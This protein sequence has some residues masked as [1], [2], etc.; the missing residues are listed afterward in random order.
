VVAETAEKLG[1]EKGQAIIIDP[2][3]IDEG[4]INL[5]EESNYDLKGVLL[6]HK[7][8]NHCYGLHCLKRIYDFE[9]Y[10]ASPL[11]QGHKSNLIKDGDVFTVGPFKIKAVSVPGHSADSMVYQINH[12]LFTGDALSAG[13]IG[14]TT[15]SFGAVQQVAALENKVFTMQGSYIVLPGHGPPSTLDA[16]RRFNAGIKRYH[17][18][19]LRRSHKYSLIMDM[20]E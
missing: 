4:I 6:T 13:M 15:N 7:H 11:V 1:T 9:L 10:A 14:R 5:I 3:A 19:K 20:M 12:L 2:G 8:L 18:R 16:E 17:A